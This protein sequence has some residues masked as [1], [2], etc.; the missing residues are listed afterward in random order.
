LD[1]ASLEQKLVRSQRGGYCY[2]Q[3]LVFE[4]ALKAAGFNVTGIGARVRW[5]SDPNSPLG[6]K[7]HML[8]KVDLGDGV[9]LSDVGFGGCM[10]D[11][12]L[13]LEID[14]EQRT[15]MGTY[16]LSKSDGLFSLEMKRPVGWRTMYVFD[17]E[18]QLPSDYEMGNWYVSTNPS[19]P[20]VSTL[21]IERVSSDRRYRLV[22]RRFTVE[23]R[24]GELVSERTL[25]SAKELGQVLEEIFEL[26]PPAP[27]EEVFASTDN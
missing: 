16:R 5:N 6:P 22:D 2:E 23:A 15:A 11:A 8:L 26:T 17:L 24:E 13:R 3:N 9:Y 7:F 14:T 18:P 19:T 27:V 12:P 10:V 25:E 20:F 4:A 21:V 1:I